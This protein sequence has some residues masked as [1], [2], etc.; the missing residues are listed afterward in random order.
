MIYSWARKRIIELL[1]FLGAQRCIYKNIRQVLLVR[2]AIKELEV[3]P[4]K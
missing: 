3:I 2:A 4:E 1:K